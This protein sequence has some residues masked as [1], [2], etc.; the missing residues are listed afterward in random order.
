MSLSRP[1]T[2]KA[3]ILFTLIEKGCVSIEDFH[4]LP[5]FRTR[6]S[7]LTRIDEIPL[8]RESKKGINK[9]GNSYTYIE[10]QLPI[11]YMGSAIVKYI[12][13]NS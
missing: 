4:Y 10:H 9:F 5:G 13:I 8:K 2:N 12:I 11:E 3:E 7:E 1:K 6:V